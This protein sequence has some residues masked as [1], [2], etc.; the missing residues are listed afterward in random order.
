MF[1]NSE[2]KN[3]FFLDILKTLLNIII[4]KLIENHSYCSLIILCKLSDKISVIFN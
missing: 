1:G 4:K 3:S 2:K